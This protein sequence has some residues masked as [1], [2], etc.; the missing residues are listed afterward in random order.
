MAPVVARCQR[1]RD[2]TVAIRKPFPNH[3]TDFTWAGEEIHRFSEIRL[4]RS[5]AGRRVA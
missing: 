3:P 5:G 4:E 1:Q 2:K